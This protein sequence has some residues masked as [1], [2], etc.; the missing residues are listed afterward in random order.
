[1]YDSFR[2]MTLWLVVPSESLTSNQDLLSS[3]IAFHNFL[4]CMTLCSSRELDLAEALINNGSLARFRSY[5][6]GGHNKFQVVQA[7]DT[8]RDW[9]VRCTLKNREEN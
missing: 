6:V 5:N 1:M 2:M 7:V 9:T 4:D 8:M 3:D